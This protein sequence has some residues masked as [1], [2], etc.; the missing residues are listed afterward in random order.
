MARELKVVVEANT[1]LHRLW[2]GAEGR[3]A[4]AENKLRLE[5]QRCEGNGPNLGV[6]QVAGMLAQSRAGMN[7]LLLLQSWICAWPIQGRT[8]IGWSAR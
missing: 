8:W 5:K 1:E 4:S 6:G 3:E 2:K 7:E